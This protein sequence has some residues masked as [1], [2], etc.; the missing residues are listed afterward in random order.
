MTGP[1]GSIV[2]PAHDEE[3]VIAR[4]LGRLVEVVEQRLVDVVVV[5]NGCS[6][7]T[8]EV[9][10]G[11]AGIRVREV[12][13][14]SKTAALREGDRIALA[15][16]RIYLD[17]DVELTGRAAVATL[18]ALAGGVIAGRPPQ[19]FDFSKAHW[20]VKRWYVVREQL[21]TTSQALWGAGCYAL[22]E[23]GRARFDEFPEVL[24]DDLFVQSLF[25]ADEVSIIDTDPVIV[26]T[27][28]TVTD[29]VR[30]KARSYRTQEW[31][32]PERT[33]RELS[34]GQRA[35]VR[36][37]VA[38]VR[39]EPKRIVDVSI[40]AALVVSARLRAR[41]SPAQRWE[42]DLSSRPGS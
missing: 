15:G 38:L 24:G 29:L 36:E 25:A 13:Q 42:R 6:D 26:H 11:F 28:R 5:C 32:R 22:S 18:H 17:A 20:V 16:P 9:A 33:Q 37:L 21:P 19:K 8:A 2:I 27:P 35:Q 41:G 39:R 4:T 14:A 40:Y 12:E 31:F 30:T 7:Q 34:P 1:L 23:Q 3:A 10:R